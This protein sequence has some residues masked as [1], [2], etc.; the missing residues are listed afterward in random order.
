MNVLHLY[1]GHEK[2][3]EGRGSVP[4]VVWNLARETAA[5]GHEVTVLERQWDGLPERSV[6]EGVRFERIPLRTG[7]TEPWEQIP[8]EM[9]SS[10]RGAATLLLDRTNFAARA[11][12]R[13]RELEFD[14]VHVHLPFA[15][16]VLATV[17]PW[18]ANRM[19]YTAHIGETETRVR[20]TRFSPDAY[21]ARRAARTIVLNPE[22][23]SAFESRGVAAEKLAVI[24]NGVD[25]DR[26]QQVDPGVCEQVR[27]EH[28]L[29]GSRI[30]LFVGTVTPRKGV[31]E[32]LR[33]AAQ[34]VGP[35]P[36]VR[37][38]IVG[39]MDME[40]TYADEVRDLIDTTGLSEHVVLTGF[41]PDEQI[42]AF[43]RLAD[44]FVLPSY[45]EGSSIAVTEA[46]ASGTPVVGTTID[47]IV[48][49]IDPGVHG[50][51]VDPGDIDGLATALAELLDDG[52]ERE[53]MARALERRADELSWEHIAER[54]VSVYRDVS[55]QR[56]VGIRPEVRS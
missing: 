41:V 5:R 14:V 8:Y 30:V 32:L 11:L 12:S 29:E 47:G 20:E 4:N 42:P 27:V 44:L 23:R 24:P 3:F 25:I 2:V 38:V 16:N 50:R 35:R 13:L 21:L 36:D 28:D 48:Q 55:G 54:I 15:G 19:V 26:F 53:A 18:I 56:N 46:I 37:L 52:A 1:D 7:P 33:A 43:Y 31:V 22:M 40:P 39:K 34:V 45:E 10:P 17:A 9:V 49:Q 6:H 51:L